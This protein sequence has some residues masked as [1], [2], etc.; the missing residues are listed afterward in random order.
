MGPHSPW[1]EQCICSINSIF[2]ISIYSSMAQTDD[3]ILAAVT[4]AL[5]AAV[6]LAEDEEGWKVEKQQGEAVIS[7]K[8]NKDDRRVWL[9][10]ATVNVPPKVLWGKIK[11]TDNLTSWNTTLTKSSTI[12]TISGDT[13][14]TYQVTSDGGGGVVSARDFVYGVKT[15]EAGNKMMIGGLSVTVAEQPEVSGMVRA[16]HGPGCQMIVDTGAADK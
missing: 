3:Q 9:C 12:K 6:Q 7:S 5:A 13:K 4:E 11:D 8:K 2:R 16:V 1:L 10:S 15:M 14:V